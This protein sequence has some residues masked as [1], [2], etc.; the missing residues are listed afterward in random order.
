MG[1]IHVDTDITDV[2]TLQ[3]RYAI[4]KSY[5][6]ELEDYIKNL[7]NLG[8]RCQLEIRDKDSGIVHVIGTNPHDTLYVKN[9]IVE[10]YN[11]QNGCGTD[12]TYE[13]VDKVAP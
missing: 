6:E 4:L 5:C 7:P 8:W 10:Y 9:G 3:M 2:E 12:G 1:V 11:L 13:F